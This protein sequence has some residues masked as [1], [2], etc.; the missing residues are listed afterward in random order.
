MAVRVAEPERLR[1]LRAPLLMYAHYTASRRARHEAADEP[2]A[3]P[4]ESRTWSSG[5]AAFQL[6]GPNI[7]NITDVSDVAFW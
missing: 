3:V 6:P 2:A 5:C 1:V 4:V 7:S